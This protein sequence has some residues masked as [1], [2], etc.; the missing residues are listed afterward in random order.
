M[1]IFVYGSLREGF[2]NF[3]KYINTAAQ[4]IQL[5]EV[6]GKLYEIK[7]KNY[8]AMLEE[9][10]IVKGEIITLENCDMDAMDKMENYFG[11]NNPQNEYNKV[12][13]E[14]KNLE[15]GE[16]EIL[17]VYIYN[18]TNPEF[19]YENLVNISSGDWR[20]FKEKNKN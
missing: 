16:I 3:D 12:S 19:S 5:G 14:I 15:T 13:K 9:D 1:K 4:K 11:E 20:E 7:G 2:F 8:P 17:E 10:G 6:N 18:K